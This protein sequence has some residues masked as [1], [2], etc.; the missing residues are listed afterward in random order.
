M[1][2]PG[3]STIGT[4]FDSHPA[5]FPDA[6]TQAV[7]Q[8]F[9]TCFDGINSADYEQAWLMLSPTLRGSSWSSFA[10]G[11]ST[12]YDSQVAL[13]SVTPGPGQSVIANVTFTSVQASVKG[14][15]G[16]TCDNW[17]L[18]YT[19]VPSDGSW[20]IDKV[21]GHNGGPTHTSG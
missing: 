15:D 10:E 13:L 20:L 7:A 3:G 1:R 17:D 5:R 21:L 4:G 12:S 6:T 14:P 2:L 8:V 11:T 16:D 18:D 9:K 19:L